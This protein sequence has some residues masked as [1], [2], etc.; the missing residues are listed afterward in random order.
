[1]T[2]IQVKVLCQGRI[3]RE[4]KV[5]LEA[6]SSVTVVTWPEHVMI[7]DSSDSEYR[8]RVIDALSAN[9]IDP[10]QVDIVVNTHLHSDHCSNNDL[11]GYAIQM[12][13]WMEGPDRRYVQVREDQE[14]YPGITLVHTPGHTAGTMSVFV[15]AER[16]Y[17]IVGDAIP[18]FENVRR[19][20]PPGVISDGEAALRSMKK[21]VS[22]ADVVVPG[23]DAPFEVDRINDRFIQNR[24]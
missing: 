24:A 13:H 9:E 20:A 10:D 14:L 23:H 2:P 7:V 6:H 8:P 15:E 19:W 12:A 17:A 22:F 5:I 16:R 21:I 1:M 11:F 4:G 3:V 18:T